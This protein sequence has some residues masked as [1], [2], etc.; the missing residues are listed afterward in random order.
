MR[1]RGQKG[2]TLIELLIVI[3]IIAILAA[4]AIPMYLNQRAK[5]KDASMKEAVHTVLV[6]IQSF[7]TDNNDVYPSTAQAQAGSGAGLQ[8]QLQG[9][10]V[11]TK[12][13]IDSWPNNPYLSGSTAM[14]VATAA[15]T[16]GTLLYASATP[17]NN[18]GLTGYLNDGSAFVGHVGS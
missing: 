15:G 16:R 11:V 7:A 18:F 17:F 12:S 14:I 10:G 6:G 8:Q 5:A 13:E 9:G 3:I 1:S 2:F 4:I